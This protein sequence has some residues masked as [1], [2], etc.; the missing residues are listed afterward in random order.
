MDDS[1]NISVNALLAQ[2]ER[3]WSRNAIVY[4]LGGQLGRD[5][6]YGLE[7]ALEHLLLGMQVGDRRGQARKLLLQVL[8]EGFL[9]RA[10][11]PVVGPRQP[12]RSV[13][14]AMSSEQAYT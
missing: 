12:T 3:E 10:L 1:E 11:L 13:R 2:A 5:L 9:D 14:V 4:N 8:G 6:L 7:L